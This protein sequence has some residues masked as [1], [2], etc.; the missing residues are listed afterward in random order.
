MVA[1]YA[2]EV[3]MQTPEKNVK[4]LMKSYERLE[5]MISVHLVGCIILFSIGFSAL[6]ILARI[7]FNYSFVGLVEIV[8]IGVVLIL[9]AS[10]AAVQLERGHVTV[11]LVTG[12]LKGRRAGAILDCIILVICISTSAMLLLLQ[13][14]YCSRSYMLNT[15]TTSLF[16]PTWPIILA[17]AVGVFLYVVRQ[18]MQLVDSIRSVIRPY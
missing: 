11:D 5:K 18:I 7:V 12:K 16:L 9:Y 1:F 4:P 6:E 8:E 14:W 10:L 17:V 15:Q 2:A 3:F 13:V